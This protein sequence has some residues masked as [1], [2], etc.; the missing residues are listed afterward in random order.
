[1]KYD[2]SDVEWHVGLQGMYLS[3]FWDYFW[4][5]EGSFKSL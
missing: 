1:M 5:R 4:K 2:K 3:A